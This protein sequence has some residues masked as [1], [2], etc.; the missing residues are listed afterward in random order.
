MTESRP[1]AAAR[2]AAR[3]ERAA[4]AT[5]LLVGRRA[6]SSLMTWEYI[7]RAFGCGPEEAQKRFGETLP[8]AEQGGEGA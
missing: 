4:G 7:G 8:G 6:R 5:A 3:F 2:A 1:Y